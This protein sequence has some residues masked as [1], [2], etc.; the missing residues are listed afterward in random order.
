MA[1]HSTVA[2]RIPQTEES[3][4]PHR[5][6]HDLAAKRTFM[7]VLG[8]VAVWLFSGCSKQGLL[9]GCSVRASRHSGFS[10]CRARALERA[11]FSSCSSHA[12]D[13]RFSGCGSLAWLLHSMWD[14]T[15][16]GIEP[17]SF[18]LT[19]RFFTTELPG[20]PPSLFK[21]I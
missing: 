5:V 8:L 1:T 7:A 15:R 9:S 16:P 2:R 11:G 12:L 3:V 21:S 18:A 14:L 20:K 19:G 4:G 10:R 17:I 13:H 6:G